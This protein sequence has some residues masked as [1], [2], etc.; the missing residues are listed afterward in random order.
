M[1]KILLTLALFTHLS[2][3]ATPEQVEQ[4][5]SVSNAEEELLSLQSQ[6]SA[7]QNAFK[8]QETNSSDDNTYDMQMLS[9]RFKD[10]LQK[11]LSEDEMTEVLEN[12]KNVVLLQFVSAS[13]E[14]EEHDQNETMAYVQQLQAS[15]EAEERIALVEKISNKLYSKEA[16]VVMFDELMKPLME[17]GIGGQKM[18]GDM[19]KATKANYLKMMTEASRYET[20]YASKDFTMDELEAL[21][22]VAKTPAI[23]HE[24]KAV[25]GAMAY[26]LKEFFMSLASRFDVSKHQPP[27]SADTKHT[28]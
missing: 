28:K 8:S 13:S 1:K 19:L 11:H 6:F 21:L 23:D 12:Y 5:L 9:I 25:F 7:M 15:P 10:Y 18:S 27:S 4:Y 16:M 17:N 3:A 24:T 22:K 2:F 14:A 20:L 26:S